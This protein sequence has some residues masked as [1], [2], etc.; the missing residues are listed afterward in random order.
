MIGTDEKSEMILL[1]DYS[2]QHS[3][4]FALTSL[5]SEYMWLVAEITKQYLKSLPSCALGTKV[6]NIFVWQK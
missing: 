3:E 4:T 6:D 5:I 2:R 1:I